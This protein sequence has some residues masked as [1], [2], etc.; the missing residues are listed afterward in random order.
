MQQ[1]DNVVRGKNLNI[2]A[3]QLEISGLDVLQSQVIEK[4]T[5]RPSNLPLTQ[6]PLFMTQAVEMMATGAPIISATQAYLKRPDWDK[7][8]K[9]S[10][11]FPRE[12]GKGRSIEFYILNH[13]EQQPGFITHKAEKE[14]LERYGVMAARLHAVFATYAAKQ[15]EPWKE[16]FNL[17]GSDLIKVLGL[18]RTNR[19]NKSQ[20][21]KAVTDLAW[22][23][24]T[25]GAEIHWYEGELDLCITRRSPIWTILYVEEFHQPELIEGAAELIEVIIRV[26]PGAW[27]EKF[28]N[29]EGEQQRKALYQYGFINQEVFNFDHYKQELAAALALYLTQN[30]RSHIKGTYRIQ[31]LLEAVM[32]AQ[33]ITAIRRVKQYR[34]RFVKKFYIVLEALTE[35][36]FKLQFAESF[37]KELLPAWAELPKENEGELDPAATAPKERQLPKGFFEI[38][39]NGVV[40]I[41]APPAIE[42]AMK[43]FEKRKVQ[44]AK[45]KP[46]GS[47]RKSH[48]V[49]GD[50]RVVET[51]TKLAQPSQLEVLTG[52]T[53]KQLRFKQGWTQA[54][55]A[56]RIG[57]SVSWVK[58]VESGRRRIKDD[59]QEAL[60]KLLGI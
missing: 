19:M 27:A 43:E 31:T 35:I 15:H 32:S 39:L 49:K 55:L 28:L 7:Y 58:L 44:I 14:I 29:K 22:I 48:R 4:R 17:Q 41:T 8:G 33:E 3:S 50:D 57:K 46:K 23:V 13:Q 45:G 60:R 18:H 47:S 16:P 11:Y 51:P 52:E 30:R 56:S 42:S 25:L 12:F 36:G 34:S 1:E 24:G 21:L 10:L 37:P 38:W 54:H 59:D 5:R 2:G 6:P 26:M 20:K 53:V 40:G 9:D